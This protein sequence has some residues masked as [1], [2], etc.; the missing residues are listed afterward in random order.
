MRLVIAQRLIP[1]PRLDGKLASNVWWWNLHFGHDLR[2]VLDLAHEPVILKT[3]EIGKLVLGWSR[4]QVCGK[5][6]STGNFQ[7]HTW[8][9]DAEP[10]IETL[11]IGV[12]FMRVVACAR[13]DVDW[14]YGC[15][16]KVIFH[17]VVDA[18]VALAAEDAVR[19]EH[20]ES[21]DIL[22]CFPQPRGGEEDGDR[23]MRWEVIVF[24]GQE[25]HF[26]G[27]RRQPFAELGALWDCPATACQDH[28]LP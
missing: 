3:Q 9:A 27:P 19:L 26:D 12:G 16:N 17:K 20:E 15:A 23:R 5:V 21:V 8:I 14:V 22:E 18:G 28:H 4:V 6:V 2:C 11:C 1:V 13:I 25:A 7:K 24:R 10:A